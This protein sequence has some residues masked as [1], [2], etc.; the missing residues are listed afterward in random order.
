ML[1]WALLLGNDHTAGFDLTKYGERIVSRLGSRPHPDAVRAFVADHASSGCSPMWEELSDPALIQ[2]VAYSHAVYE[3]G[4]TSQFPLDAAG[5]Q[6]VEVEV[7]ARKGL[8]MS[9]IGAIALA[10]VA[11]SVVGCVVVRH[12]PQQHGYPSRRHAACGER[13]V[14]ALRRILSGERAPLVV[15]KATPGIAAVAVTAATTSNAAATSASATE[16]DRVGA[17]AAVVA[18]RARAEMRLDWSDVMVGRRYEEVCRLLLRCGL[19]GPVAPSSLFDGPSF[20]AF[21]QVQFLTLHY[22]TTH[23]TAPHH[24]APHRTAPRHTALSHATPNYNMPHP[25]PPRAPRTRA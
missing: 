21:C 12:P 2:A 17:I 10:E 19:F 13:H 23:R 16:A 11:S 24:T 20:H 4:D 1:D 8:D 7:I 15:A 14:Y 18:E 22:T 25:T 9:S 3:H 5:L 6:E